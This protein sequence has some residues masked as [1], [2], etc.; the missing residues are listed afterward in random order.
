M[1]QIKR[2]VCNQKRGNSFRFTVAVLSAASP[3]P[4]GSILVLGPFCVDFASF[5][6]H[7]RDLSGFLPQPQKIHMRVIGD[8]ILSLGVNVRENDCISLCALR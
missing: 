4:K 7:L 6:L 3:Q 5:F 2:E 8:S 1:S